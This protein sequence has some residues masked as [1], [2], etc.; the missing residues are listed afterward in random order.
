MKTN[1]SLFLALC[2]LFL[3]NNIAAMESSARTRFKNTQADKETKQQF[4]S[5]YQDYKNKGVSDVLE[6][7]NRYNEIEKVLQ[8]VVRDCYQDNKLSP[9]TINRWAKFKLE[10]ASTEEASIPEESK[11]E[12][13][14]EKER[15]AGFECSN[16]TLQGFINYIS[17]A[18]QFQEFVQQKLNTNK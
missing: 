1:K 17:W 4:E 10:L 7:V 5:F 2:A 15:L 11:K 18:R 14:N 12:W 6:I 16:D 8:L 9:S 3:T 13:E